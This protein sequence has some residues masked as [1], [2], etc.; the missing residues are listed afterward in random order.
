MKATQIIAA[1]VLTLTGA[2]AFAAGN[3]VG[4]D[5]YVS[6]PIPNSFSHS[7][8][9]DKTKAEVRAE[10]VQARAEG[11]LVGGEEYVSTVDKNTTST[12][13]RAEVKA[14][15]IKAAKNGSRNTEYSFGG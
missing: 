14:E 9:S 3:Q 5:A 15:A 11:Q 2:A 13:S 7:A 10:L 6:F 4:G 8:A 12:L 1:A